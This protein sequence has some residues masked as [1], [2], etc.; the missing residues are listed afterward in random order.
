[1]IPG[2]TDFSTIW[3]TYSYNWRKGEKNMF[4]FFLQHACNA[5]FM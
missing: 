1:M 2:L 3:R 5:A 4:L